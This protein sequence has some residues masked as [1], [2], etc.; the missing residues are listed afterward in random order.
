MISR[1]FAFRELPNF[2]RMHKT[3]VLAT[4]INS[5]TL[6]EAVADR[7]LKMEQLVGKDYV[8]SRKR[9][10]VG[11]VFS[12]PKKDYC[13]NLWPH[14]PLSYHIIPKRRFRKTTT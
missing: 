13:Y 9:A 6:L 4:L 7:N 11:R 8:L 12:S 10:T 2:A 1:V 3:L 14:S 5:H